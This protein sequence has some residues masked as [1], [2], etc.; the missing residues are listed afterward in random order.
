[1]KAA[2][3]AMR[4]RSAVHRTQG[5][6]TG[7]RTLRA[8]GLVERDRSEQDTGRLG[9]LSDQLVQQHL[10][11]APAAHPHGVGPFRLTKGADA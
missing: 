11:A 5:A 10:R 4:R 8:A 2:V 9:V 3:S 1:M 7:E 6:T